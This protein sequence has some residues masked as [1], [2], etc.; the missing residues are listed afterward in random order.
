MLE[1]P[2]NEGKDRERTGSHL[3]GR[4]IAIAKRHA[5]VL[6]ADDAVVRERDAED[7]RGQVFECRCATPNRPA[8]HDPGLLPRSW[9]YVLGEI[10]LPYGG[11]Q[12][13]PKQNR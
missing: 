5:V 13:C 8:V 11:T 9:W 7:V 2:L 10:R 1:K 4:A 12:L 3:L 6:H